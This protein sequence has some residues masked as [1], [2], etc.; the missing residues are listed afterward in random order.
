MKVLFFILCL[1]VLLFPAED[2]IQNDSVTKNPSF[3]EKSLYNGV[4]FRD[5]LSEKFTKFSNHVDNFLAN[6]TDE[7][8]QENK[9]F[10]HFQY[11]IEKIQHNSIDNN[12][13]VSFRIKIPKAKKKY[14]IELGSLD[15]RNNELNGEL[16]DARID[17]V[18][19]SENFAAGIGYGKQ[20]KEYLN[21]STG[22]GV[23]IKLDELDPYVKA[24]VIRVINIADDWKSDFAQQFYLFNKRGL[25]STTSFE[26][27]KT[28]NEIFKF[29]NYNE[30]F[31]KEQER[32]DNF[33]NSFRLFQTI[34][35]KDSL[36]YIASASTNNV[37][38]N[39][40]VK[41]YQT[42]V[43]Y[44]HFFKKWFY[45]DVIPKYIWLRE[46]DFNPRY[47]IRFNIGMF[48]GER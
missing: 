12:I 25:E 36:S 27:Y 26:I 8:F 2:I 5:Y 17:D 48:L 31:W 45:Y 37:D 43:A 20:L 39:M 9:S 32:D 30:F 47:A 34:S 15:K 7:K 6:E 21:F 24:K 41:N 38:S 35:E 19:K 13:D 11:A 14:R 3:L 33:Y 18:S 29:S 10:I 42:Y 22:I 46:D 16:N 4:V 44:R 28:Y 23:R 1:N 40:Q